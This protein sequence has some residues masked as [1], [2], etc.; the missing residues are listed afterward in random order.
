MKVAYGR[1]WLKP[2]L[3]KKLSKKQ[4]ARVKCSGI[5]VN[6]EEALVMLDAKRV[7]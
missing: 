1:R 4:T 2:E 3:S 5:S 6:V 7:M